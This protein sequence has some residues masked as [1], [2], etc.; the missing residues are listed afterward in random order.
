MTGP[1]I[2]YRVSYSDRVQRRLKVLAREARQ[3]GDGDPFT[4]ALLEFD[5]RLHIYP[6]FGEPS[7]D[8]TAEP[9]QIYKGF[10]RPL[11]MRYAVYE[12]R[13]LVMVGDLPVLLPKLSQEPG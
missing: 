8:L 13:R 5:R 3:R 2:P 11:A 4:T 9:G 7:M 1:V 12:E 10:V 6:Q